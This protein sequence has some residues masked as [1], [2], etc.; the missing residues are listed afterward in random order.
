[1]GENSLKG[2]MMKR[3]GEVITVVVLVFIALGFITTLPIVYQHTKKGIASHEECKEQRIVVPIWLNEKCVP[4][5]QV[6][7]CNE[8]SNA[9]LM[10]CDPIRF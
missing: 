8:V 5:V 7:K 6:Y 1:M 3:N 4:S 10:Q 9:N 2:D